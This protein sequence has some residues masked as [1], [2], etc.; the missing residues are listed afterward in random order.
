M[1]DVILY[2]REGHVVTITYNRPESMNAINGARQGF[3]ATPPT[4]PG[5][6]FSPL[7]SCGPAELRREVNAAFARFR[8]DDEAWVCI[9][10][11]NGR[12][13]CAGADLKQ[14]VRSPPFAGSAQPPLT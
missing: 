9:V 1:S 12:C 4:P 11:G 8:D 7:R 6:P 14:G 10:T 3:V 5:A 2:S 13:F